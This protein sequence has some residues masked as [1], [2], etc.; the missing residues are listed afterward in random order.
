MEPVG[1]WLGGPMNTLFFIFAAFALGVSPS[2]AFACEDKLAQQNFFEHFNRYE[3]FLDNKISRAEYAIW[4]K[5]EVRPRKFEGHFRNAI[6]FL[7][8]YPDFKGQLGTRPG[9]AAKFRVDIVFFTKAAAK[10]QGFETARIQKLL[11]LW[12]IAELSAHPTISRLTP[13]PI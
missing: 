10:E 7:T 13:S 3:D 1:I 5:K 12:Q 6:E 4:L 11:P 2:S 8:N 9:F